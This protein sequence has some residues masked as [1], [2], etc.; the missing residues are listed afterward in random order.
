EFTLL[1]FSGTPIRPRFRC[2]AEIIST[3]GTITFGLMIEGFVNS[4]ALSENHGNAGALDFRITF[5]SIQ[6]E[7]VVLL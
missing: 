6:S 2:H 1:M 7:K 4:G 3:L 5:H